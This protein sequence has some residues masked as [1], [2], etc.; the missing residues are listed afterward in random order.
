MAASTTRPIIV[1]M[2]GSDTARRALDAAI[3]LATLEGATVVAVHAVGLIDEVGGEHVPT[4]GHRTEIAAALAAW[5][6]NAGASDAASPPVR[7][8]PRLV[9]GPPVDVL[10]RIA[11]ETDASTIVVGRRGVGGRP[12]LL[13]GSTAHQVLE[14]ADRAV[15]V[16]PPVDR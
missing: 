8:E 3:R 9:E 13:L 15:L 6:S 7:I 5:C 10:L 14:R 4:F 12:D 16:I 11:E 2:D 1:G